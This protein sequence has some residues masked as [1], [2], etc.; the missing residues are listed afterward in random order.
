MKPR[1]WKLFLY[2]VADRLFPKQMDEAYEQGIRV[3]AEYAA[4]T[5]SFTITEAGEKQKLTKAQTVGF[6]VACKAVRD[7]KK[8]IHAR[9]GAML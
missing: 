6:E 4:R 5:M 9:T 1:N 2:D 7:A 8:K 3:G